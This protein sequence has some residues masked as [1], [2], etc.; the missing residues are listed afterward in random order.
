IENNG[1][2]VQVNDVSNIGNVSV[3]REIASISN[4]DYIYWSSPVVNFNVDGIYSGFGS[5]PLYKY[6]WDPVATNANGTQGNWIDA[7][8]MNM[9]IGRG[10][11]VRDPSYSFNPAE[12]VDFNNGIPHNGTIDVEIRRG[13]NGSSVD[14]NWNL[15]GNPYASSIDAIDFLIDNTNIDGFVYLW[16]HLNDPLTSNPDPFYQDFV[17]NYDA[18]DYV[19]YNEMGVSD[20]IG[21]NG[22]IATG[23]SFMVSMLESG[24]ATQNVTFDNTLRDIVYDNSQFYSPNPDNNVVFGEST[25][26]NSTEFTGKHRIWLDLISS[27]E[28]VDRILV[29]YA[30][31][32]T[33]ARDRMYD[34]LTTL[35]N[36]QNF[37]SLIDDEIFVIQGRGLPFEETD[38]I[39]LGMQI[40]SPG[41]YHIGM[42]QIDGIFEGQDQPVYLRDGYNNFIHNL[43]ESPYNFYSEAGLIN[44]RFD[45]V[46]INETLDLDDIQTDSYSLI[47][48]EDQNGNFHIRVAENLT[49]KT[50]EI[51]D[52]LGRKVLLSTG[53][54]SSNIQLNTSDLS[55]SA[56]VVTVEVENGARLVRKVVKRY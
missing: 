17:Y 49:I 4:Y 56:Y 44:D 47:I 39:P 11:I 40:E 52:L 24:A 41:Q 31:G 51:N 29:G 50:V 53:L 26:E 21:F 18:D 16:R 54:N 48:Y 12:T 43:K 42:A 9:E 32:A 10:Y 23:Q 45:I 5:S 14:D 33:L 22:Y 3:K 30:E 34:A 2:L 7:T 35:D 1:S 55:Q 13:T 6:Y 36:T 37:Y 15:I 8:G 46:F 19:A 27:D 20:P 25:D 28:D 38:E